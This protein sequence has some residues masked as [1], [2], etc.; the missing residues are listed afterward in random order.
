MPKKG[1]S[2]E[3][4][5][6]ALHQAESGATVKEVCREHGVSDATFYIWKK[7]YAGLG[8]SELRELRQLREE[9]GKLKRLVADLS[10]D[11]HILQ[12]IVQK[13]L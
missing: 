13:K 12:E 7:K 2:E 4:I 5:L 9:N 10:L 6:R 8:L 11:R 3:Q 1:H